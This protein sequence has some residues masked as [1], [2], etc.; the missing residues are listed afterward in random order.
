MKRIQNEH[1]G[2]SKDICS[3]LLHL[4]DFKIE[5]HLLNASNILFIIARNTTLDSLQI[6][7]S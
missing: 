2:T 3:E 4:K 5:K 7:S 6:E 1:H